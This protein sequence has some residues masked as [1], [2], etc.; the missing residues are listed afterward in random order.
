MTT[1]TLHVF[2][3]ADDGTVVLSRDGVPQHDSHLIIPLHYYGGEPAWGDVLRMI[4]FFEPQF[5]VISE[6][7]IS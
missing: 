1:Y 3:H 7:G 6:R 2:L 4:R 5:V